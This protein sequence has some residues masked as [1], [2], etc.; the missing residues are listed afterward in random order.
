MDDL[1]LQ[2]QN[3]VDDPPVGLSYTKFLSRNN[4]R[5]NIQNSFA[6]YKKGGNESR[7]TSFRKFNQSWG[8][9]LYRR[10]QFQ[11]KVKTCSARR[12]VKEPFIGHDIYNCLNIATT[13]G[14]N[15]LKS[16]A[17]DINEDPGDVESDDD[18]DQLNASV[19]ISMDENISA[20]VRRIVESPYFNVKLEK[21]TVT[22]VLDTGAKGSMISLDLCKL[23]HLDVYPTTQRAVL[24]DGDHLTV[25]GEVHTKI[26]MNSD[27][28]LPLSALVVTKLTAGLI[29]GMA[30][31]KRH[32]VII[33]IA[34]NAF[35]VR[36]N[37][38]PFDNQPGNPKMS[39]L[40]VDVN[41]VVLPGESITLPTPP[42][43]S[44]DTHV[45]VEPRK[46]NSS[47]PEPCIVEN[48]NGFLTI[49]N[50]SNYPVKFKGNQ[51]IGQ[52]R[53]VITPTV[54]TPLPVT[55]AYAKINDRIQPLNCL[56]SIHYDQDSI[57]T[58]GEKTCLQSVTARYASV[59]TP[60]FGT[61]NGKS[62]GIFADV[63][64]GKIS[65]APKKGKL[66]VYN[67]KNSKVLQD[68][69]DELV[70]LGVLS[71]LEDV[72]VTVVHTSPSFL[73][74][75]SNGSHRPVKSFVELNK[76]ICPLPSKIGTTTDVITALGRWKYIIKTDLKS[77][78]FQMQVTPCSQKWLGTISP[79]KSMYVYNRG[80]MGLKNMAEYLEEI[81]TRVIGDCLAEGILAKISDDLIIGANSI[82]D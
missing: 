35:L 11:P 13:N 82:A 5:G 2:A 75:K 81:V 73:V 39:L 25:V 24:A 33:N 70:E 69:F 32:K 36:G 1:L 44:N 56:D 10:E 14:T 20:H 47:W 74:K 27:V 54:D 49:P 23:A 17:L 63:I 68:K 48:E 72:D 51:I 52:I 80:P 61:Y 42:N 40:R 79:Y 7:N 28:I 4:Q 16:F 46:P 67:S 55:T 50:F 43:F 21:T 62:G 41:R 37:R 76:Y 3:K 9:S 64:V 60:H 59:F 71:R 6:S 65:P 53:L 29:V 57:L 26:T 30:F 78:Y 58:P 15:L 38:V 18:Q 34:N 19:N 22:L 45:A 31:M 77:S 8:D 66:P 12:S